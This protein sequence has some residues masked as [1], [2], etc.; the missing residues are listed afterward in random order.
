M[1]MLKL[2]GGVVLLNVINLFPLTGLNAQKLELLTTKSIA[3]FD[4]MVADHQSGV[5]ISKANGDIDRVD[6]E[7]KV[8]FTFSPA[9]NGPV[10]QID[11]WSPF[12]IMVFYDTF[13]EIVVLNRFL[14]ETVRHELDSYDLGFVSNVAFNFQQRLWV[15]DESD[16]SLKL[17][18]LKNGNVFVEQPFFQFLDVDNHEITFMREFKGHLY[19]VD[20]F[21]G[22]LV[23][24]NLGNLIRKI[25]GKGIKYLGFETEKLYY[26]DGNKLIF[27]GLYDD[28]EM[29]ITLPQGKYKN[30][31]KSG[32]YFFCASDSQLDIYRYLRED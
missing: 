9:K 15:M 30:V 25:D 4:F 7:G 27:L 3:N 5:V 12:K 17:L 22:V 2:L 13:Q 26:L 28:S 6:T 1:G 29:V 24:D 14:T 10:K 23:F 18:D 21:A 20:K 16:F 19:V 32:D 11:V 31:Q 8:L